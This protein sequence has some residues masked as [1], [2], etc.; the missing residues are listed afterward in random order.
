M[1]ISLK[2]VIKLAY[3]SYASLVDLY[4]LLWHS[5]GMAGVAAAAAATHHS[6]L[7]KALPAFVRAAAGVS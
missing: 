2:F 7:G 4:R 3:Y 1:H 5:P 6:S